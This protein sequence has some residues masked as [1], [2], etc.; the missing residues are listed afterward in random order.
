MSEKKYIYVCKTADIPRGQ[1]KNFLMQN[2]EIAIFNTAEGFF[3]H[4][5]VCKH[6]AHK[7]ELCEIMGDV[8]RCPRHH[9]QYEISTGKGLRPNH[10]ALDNFPLEIRGEEIWVNLEAEASADNDFDTSMYQW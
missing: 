10:T 5:G 2:K 3:A 4:S 1:A 8:V 7:L 6:N 9:W